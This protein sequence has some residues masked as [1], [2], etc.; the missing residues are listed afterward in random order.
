MDY[1]PIFMKLADRPC[2]VIG[3]LFARTAPFFPS[4]PQ[5]KSPGGTPT[6]GKAVRFPPAHRA[7]SG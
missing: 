3:P 5:L 1:L 7:A 4:P 6:S 2:A